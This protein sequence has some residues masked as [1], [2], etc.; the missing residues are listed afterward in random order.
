MDNICPD[1]EKS[2]L[3]PLMKE[4]I[5]YPKLTAMRHQLLFAILLFITSSVCLGQTNDSATS[6]GSTKFKTNG[7]KKFW[8]G[9]TIYS[10]T[11]CIRSK[12]QIFPG[13]FFKYHCWQVPATNQ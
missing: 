7:S 3:F 12:Q 13:R 9:F 8:M 4:K 11:A 6:V 10:Y 2:Y 1:F 5:N